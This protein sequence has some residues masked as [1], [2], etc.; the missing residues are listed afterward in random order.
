[1]C[2]IAGLY[3]PHRSDP[4]AVAVLD[5]MTEAVRHRGPDDH[6]RFTAPGVGLGFRRLSI[7]DLVAGHQPVRSQDGT[8]VS[9]CNGEVYNHVALRRELEAAGHRFVSRSDTEIIPALYQ[10]FGLDFARRINGQFAFA[11]YDQSRHRLVLGR[12]QIGIAPLFFAQ[13]ASGVVFGSEIK[14]LLAHPGVSREVDLRGLDQILSFPGLVSPQTMVRGV[15]SLPPGTVMVFEADGSRRSLRYWD[16][17]YPPADEID[18][19]RR[20]EDCVNEL[21]AALTQSI[22]YRLQADVPVGN[23]LSGGLD[24]S[25]IAA[26]TRAL[27]PGERRNTFSITFDDAR[28]D[29]SRYQHLMVQ[30]LD[31]RHH[32]VCMRPEDIESRLADIVR[33]A[34]A[35]LRESYNACTLELSRLARDA[36]VKVVLTG[37]GADELFGGYVGY[38][39]DMLRQA[40]PA[41]ETTWGSGV[42][43]EDDDLADLL[44]RQMRE[45]L[46][47]DGDFFYEKAHHAFRDTKRAFYAADRQ[48]AFAD[49]DCLQPGL[50]NPDRLRGRHPFHQ[51]SYLDFKLRMAD[52][53]LADHGDR[54]SYVHGVEARYPFLDVQVIEVASRIPP[55]LMVHEGEE[56]FV[57]KQLARRYL[58]AAIVDRQ[59]FSFVAPSSSSLARQATPQVRALLSP[60]RIARDGVFDPAAVAQLQRQ[61]LRPGDEPNQ[62]FDDDVLMVVLTFNL[63]MDLF[64]L[65]VPAPV[66][67][68]VLEVATA[69]LACD[70]DAW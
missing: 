24:S 25:L 50:V 33:C 60:Q 54:V 5:A 15:E 2:G 61:G 34:E 7:V 63:F 38:R 17:D 53:L 32:S 40:S 23:Y 3:H 28:I 55:H 14:A 66:P 48:R 35:P 51:R 47:G 21:D 70:A 44:E 64:G 57:L 26:M 18:H 39:L 41:A 52:H 27:N 37:E 22:R 19:G 12:D 42:S 20:L 10:T 13:T 46:W 45:R 43:G 11:V 8:V 16:L 68:P 59:K 29:E 69:T 1:M 49:I 58:P 62:T 67:V 56:K 36:G 4:V 65:R 9:V 30:A 31:S 6:G